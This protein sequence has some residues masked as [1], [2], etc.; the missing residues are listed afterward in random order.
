MPGQRVTIIQ[1]VLNTD[2]YREDG[3]S[4]TYS[5]PLGAPVI[6]RVILPDYTLDVNFP[7]AMTKLDTGL[8][9]FSFTLPTGATSVGTYI[10]DI[11]WYHPTTHQLQ[12][13][14]IQV[15]VTAPYGLYSA[16]VPTAGY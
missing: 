2:G 15:A 11:Y 10:V 7:A 6:A 13:E 5:G 12:Q 4:F 14:I 8:Y 3:Y 9:V 16:T 1:Q